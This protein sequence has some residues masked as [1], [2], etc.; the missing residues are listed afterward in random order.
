MR[1]YEKNRLYY[2]AYGS[3]LHPMRLYK[4]LGAVK[5]VDVGVLKGAKIHFNKIGRDGS[6][7]CNIEF[8]GSM[9]DEVFGVLYQISNGQKKILDQAESAGRGY[10][11]REVTV[12]TFNADW[13]VFTYVAMPKFVDD[14]IKPFSW[15]KELVCLG[16]VYHKFPES[17]IE[18]LE[19]QEAIP[20]SDKKRLMENTNLI[21]EIR[22]LTNRCRENGL[23][24]GQAQV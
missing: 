9:A 3:N 12:A 19:R 24:G 15:Y 21:A 20:D 22:K 10:I 11:E 13:R 17:Y 16:A 23:T 1:R 5:F 7:K 2:F 8:T 18:T 14:S 4:R 6:G